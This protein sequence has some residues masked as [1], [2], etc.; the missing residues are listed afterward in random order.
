VD[1]YRTIITEF[2]AHGCQIDQ[3]SCTPAVFCF[4][5]SHGHRTPAANWLTGTDTLLKRFRELYKGLDPDH[6]LRGRF[7]DN[8]GLTVAGRDI[9]FWRIDRRDRRG[10]LVN[11]WGRGRNLADSCEVRVMIPKGL[12]KVRRA[13]PAGLKMDRAG[14]WLWLSW[15]G[16]LATVVFEP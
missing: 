7:M 10:M 3:T 11:F 16:P 4:D 2:H 9:K 12:T 14:D 13:F 1:Q 8:V 15:T 5:S 6:F